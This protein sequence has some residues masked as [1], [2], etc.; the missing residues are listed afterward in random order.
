MHLN[1]RTEPQSL[2]LALHSEDLKMAPFIIIIWWNQAMFGSERLTK[3]RDLFQIFLRAFKA[4]R[5]VK[6]I[7]RGTKKIRSFLESSQS[8]FTIFRRM[9]HFRSAHSIKHQARHSIVAKDS[10]SYSDSF[11]FC[12]F[13]IPSITRQNQP[14]LWN[15]DPMPFLSASPFPSFNSFIISYG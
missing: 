1:P 4:I 2:L 6:T 7:P 5:K 15:R 13:P 12:F 14:L 11:P 9:P 8:I 3:V 10:F